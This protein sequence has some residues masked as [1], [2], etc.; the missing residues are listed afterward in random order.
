[1]TA[2]CWHMSFIFYLPPELQENGSLPFSGVSWWCRVSNSS[3]FK[4]CVCWCSLLTRWWLK[5]LNCFST[6]LRTQLTVRVAPL[7]SETAWTHHRLSEL[8]HVSSTLMWAV[9]NFSH[10]LISNNICWSTMT[11]FTAALFPGR[12]E[13]HKTLLPDSHRPASVTQMFNL[14]YLDLSV[15]L[16]CIQCNLVP[17]TPHSAGLI[18]LPF[19][20][21][22]TLTSRSC[23]ACQFEYLMCWAYLFLSKAIVHNLHGLDRISPGWFQ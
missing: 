22:G 12:H 5:V 8:D 1:M 3:K 21:T 19:A 14:H 15:Q 7:D 4:W 6:T 2:R 18:T 9:T 23:S 20:S 17:V 11:F 10:S 16:P 13:I